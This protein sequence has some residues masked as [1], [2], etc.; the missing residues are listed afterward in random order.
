M[1]ERQTPEREVEGS[2]LPPR[3]CVLEQDTFLPETTG[4][5]QEAVALS[6]HD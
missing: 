3:C 5:T 6:R 2:N 4:N 1:V